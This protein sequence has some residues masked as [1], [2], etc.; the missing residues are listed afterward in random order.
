[1]SSTTTPVIGLFKPIPGTAEPFRVADLNENMDLLD[2]AYGTIEPLIDDVNG[3]IQNADDATTAAVAAT[4]ATTAALAEFE[5]DS[6]AALASIDTDA[7][8]STI[9][10]EGYSLDINGGTA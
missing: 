5:T 2:A 8:I 6:A 10:T 7:V 9:L 1:M 4:T 3:A